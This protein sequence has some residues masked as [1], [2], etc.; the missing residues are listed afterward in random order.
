MQV[1]TLKVLE[2]RDDIVS[3][4]VE[5]LKNEKQSSYPKAGL[6]LRTSSFKENGQQSTERRETSPGILQCH[7]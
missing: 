5:T 2:I 7:E 1:R 3:L 4:L 6:I